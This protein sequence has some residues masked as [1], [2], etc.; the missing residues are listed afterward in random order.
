MFTTSK[1]DLV[2]ALECVA[3]V[4]SKKAIQ[5]MLKCARFTVG[6]SRLTLQATD[7]FTSVTT[8]IAVD[9]GKPCDVAIDAAM[10]LAR[11]KSLEE[12]DV[13]LETNGKTVSV[14][15]A[16]ARKFTLP[17]ASGE[18]FPPLP[19]PDAAEVV[20]EIKPSALLRVLD[21]T[22]YAA[23]RDEQRTHL[24]CVLLRMQA[25]KMTAA[26]TDG[27]RIA[28][29]HAMVE[30]ARAAGDL[31][32]PNASVAELV[33][34]AD[35]DGEGLVTIA[36]QDRTIVASRGATSVSLKTVD[37]AFPPFE[38]IVDSLQ[39]EHT[40]T[41]SRERLIE[42]L[43]AVS[44]ASDQTSGRVVLDL[45]ADRM[46]LVASSPDAGEFVDEFSA[47][48]EGKPLRI[49]FAWRIFADA[50]AS[51]SDDEV[52]IRFGGELAPAFLK[53]DDTTAIVMPQRL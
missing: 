18:D 7:L 35:G 32:V 38:H 16:K 8:S 12:G 4:A 40:V 1:R 23:S 43:K 5:P 41:C 39:C 22:R 11:L 25:G 30:G 31:L 24:A 14:R 28:I 19:L 2:R 13:V 36:A 53:T 42:G 6:K 34:V 37:A 49:A 48:L 29:R 47:S 27:H 3:S 46:R 50:L 51:L 44:V 17:V 15:S 10:M 33:R 26:A 20:A 9:K 45:A 52:V 21:G